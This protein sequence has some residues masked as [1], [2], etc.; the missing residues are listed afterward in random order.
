MPMSVASQCFATNRSIQTVYSDNTSFVFL[1]HQ[2]EYLHS[3]RG[4]EHLLVLLRH[5]VDHIVQY[6]SCQGDYYIKVRHW[7]L[8]FALSSALV[9]HRWQATPGR[10]FPV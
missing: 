3:L 4:Q 7:V 6:P 2:Q 10:E 9:C 5:E 1:P 8:H